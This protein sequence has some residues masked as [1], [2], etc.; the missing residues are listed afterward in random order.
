MEPRSENRKIVEKKWVALLFGLCFLVYFTTYLGR[1]NYSASLAEMIRVEG[2]GKGQAGMIGTLFFASYGAGQLISG[3]LGDRLSGRWMVFGGMAVS[4]ILN[5]LMGILREP[6]AMAGVWCINGLAQAFIWSPMVKML[7]DYLRTETRI[8]S[9]LYL[10][11][12]VPLGTMAAYG[13]TAFLINGF[14]WRSAFLVP[15]VVLAA[16]AVVWFVGIGQVEWHAERLG[17]PQ[18]GDV[19]VSSER[20]SSKAL[21]Q[22]VKEEN[23]GSWKALLTASGLCWLTLALCMQ[24]ALK[25]GVTTWIPTYL[26]EIHSMGSMAAILSTM[27]IP[28][29]NLLGVTLASFVDR[30]AGS[31]EVRTAGIFFGVCAFS[32]G[33]LRLWGGKS[34]ILA[35]V[36]LAVSTT[37]MMAVNTMLIAVL[38]SRF[39]K[40]GKASS[41]SGVLNSCVYVGGAVSTYGIG[42]L[43]ASWGWDS[44]ILLWVGGAVLSLVVCVFVYRKWRDYTRNVLE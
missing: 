10:N 38:P 40:L 29:F 35:L 8:R 36:M 16:V 39:G 34:V 30:K 28:M 17:R 25:D 14:G 4:A 11:C 42:A 18:D 44:T 13:L 22:E 26:E 15:S 21:G 37:S 24:G 33:V 19:Y 6:G 41:V 9:C 23:T 1:L 43:S 2:F 3:F 5:A 20:F 12:S 7:Y 27:L 31:N 32:L